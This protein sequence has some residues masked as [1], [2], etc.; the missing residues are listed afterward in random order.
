MKSASSILV[1]SFCLVLALGLFPSESWALTKGAA[2]GAEQTTQGEGDAEILALMADAQKLK[3]A[4]PE[5]STD[6]A[7]SISKLLQQLREDKNTQALVK[8]L[9]EEGIANDPALKEYLEKADQKELV[10]GLSQLLDELKATEVLFQNPA[11]AVEEMH[12]AGMI[13]SENLKTYRE[14][15]AQLEQDLR[16]ALHFSFVSFALTAGFL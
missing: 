3:D 5:V 15:P 4:A 7:L 2:G 10:M 11:G 16:G 8:N 13:P 12:K 14:N 6:D 1:W 9:K